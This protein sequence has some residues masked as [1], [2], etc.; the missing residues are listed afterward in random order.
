LRKWLVNIVAY[1]LAVGCQLAHE[2]QGDLRSVEHGFRLCEV[3]PLVNERRVLLG[4]AKEAGVGGER[5]N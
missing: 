2:K 3:D 1:G 5:S 4:M